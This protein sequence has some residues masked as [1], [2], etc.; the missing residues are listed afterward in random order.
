MVIGQKQKYKNKQVKN[1]GSKEKLLTLDNLITIVDGRIQEMLQSNLQEIDLDENQIKTLFRQKR[2]LRKMLSQC[3]TGDMISKKY[4]KD[5]IYRIITEQIGLTQVQQ[6]YIFPIHTADRMTPRD[7]FEVMLCCYARSCAS[8]ALD[9]FLTE[10]HLDEY[11]NAEGA[12]EITAQQIQT[13]YRSGSYIL[14]QE[15]HLELIVQRIYAEYRGL[16]VIDEIRDMD[17]DGVS[18]GVN[19][20]DKEEHSVWIMFH[21]KSIYLSFLCFGSTN[22]L[23]RIC[24]TI[25][26][27]GQPGQLSKSRGYIVNE[28]ADHARIVVARPDFSESWVF[29]VRKLDNL[30]S[31]KLE[32]LFDGNHVEQ[33][34]LLLQY[35]VKGCQ[36]IG[37]TGQQGSGKTTLLMSL[38]EFVAGHLTL[39][40]QESAFELHLR[41]L[42]PERN[43][44]TFRETNTISGQEGLDLQKKT[45][46]AVSIVGEVANAGQAA[47]MLQ[48]GQS[49]SLYTMFTHHAN[50][51]KNLVWALQNSLIQ[52]GQFTKEEI[53]QRQVADVVRFHVHLV[54]NAQGRRYIDTITEIVPL[55]HPTKQGDWFV[56][57]ELLSWNGTGYE[58]IHPVSEQT[59]RQMALYLTREERRFYEEKL[60]CGN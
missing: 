40:I 10:H 35:I 34:V 5:V 56:V 38:I 55:L 45:D 42:Y 2:E 37:I 33:A 29:F 16:G 41:R 28:M 58:W 32:E 22:K 11:Q 27:H 3:G 60:V 47:L 12:Y 6:E 25:Y 57:R 39:R 30:S 13:V 4:V 31:W 46:G 43:I 49:A 8:R 23:Q 59:Q 26:R 9:S 21:G 18:G 51:T 52:T 20:A 36:T 53:A 19:G 1:K 7:M 24:R 17:I 54:K 50:S 15:E 48:L 44:V 14:T